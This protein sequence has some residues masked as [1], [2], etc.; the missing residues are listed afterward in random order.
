MNDFSSKSEATVAVGGRTAPQHRAAGTAP[1]G[2]IWVGPGGRHG[3]I[4]QTKPPMTAAGEQMFIQHP[5]HADA[6]ADGQQRG[7]EEEQRS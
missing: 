3:G 6:H 4:R 2:T 7:L 5:A 1:R